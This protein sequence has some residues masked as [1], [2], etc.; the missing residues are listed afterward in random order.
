MKRRVA[1][2]LVALG[3]VVGAAAI[4]RKRSGT[5]KERADVY[6]ADGSMVSFA[7]GSD[8]AARLFPVARRILAQAR[9]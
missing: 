1:A 6:F 7:G 4:W 9:S 8:E 2:A 5:G 3:S